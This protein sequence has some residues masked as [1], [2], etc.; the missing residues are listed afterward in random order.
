M[1]KD[2]IKKVN[3][4]YLLISLVVFSIISGLFILREVVIQRQIDQCYE[5]ARERYDEAIENVK[6]L[7]AERSK[8]DEYT[9]FSVWGTEDVETKM[10][11]RDQ[12]QKDE[13]RCLKRYK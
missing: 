7:P 1:K 5:E 13:D 8:S 4:K 10:K 6:E 12:L 3:F 9:W 2:I 11:L